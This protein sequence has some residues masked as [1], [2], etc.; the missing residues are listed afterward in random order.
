M[1]KQFRQPS[2]L[3][4][5][6]APAGLRPAA[7]AVD[8]WAAHLAAAGPE[9]RALLSD[10]ERA[11]AERFA[12]PAAGARWAAARGILRALLGRALDA[13]PRALRFV[14]GPHG[15][16]AVAAGEFVFETRYVEGKTR[17]RPA[18]PAA[19]A[20]AA[21]TRLRFNLSHSGDLALY[22]VALDREVGVDVELPRRRPVDVVAVAR[23]ALGEDAARRLA[24]LDPADRERAF[25]RAW[26]RWE[27]E[28]KCRG[29]GVGG[30]QEPSTGPPPWVRELD[31]GP[32][33]TAALAVEGGPCEVRCWRWLG[34]A[35]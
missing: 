15:K 22:A 33:A 18:T 1:S 3:E 30:A 19:T 34:A 12:D 21:P 17:D 10:D 8:V 27:A 11:R 32:P 13:D 6:P 24:A 5:P 29:V 16:P 28:L 35:A 25:L 23:R 20:S 9:A 31:P 14:A 26:T 4:W 7:G 2:R